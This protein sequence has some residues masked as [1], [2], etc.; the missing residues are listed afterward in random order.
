MLCVISRQENYQDINDNVEYVLS[1]D[2]P[3]LCN[4][5]ISKKK[6]VMIGFLSTFPD[7]VS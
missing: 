6:T 4:D 1:Y 7:N 2:E 3:D 5:Y